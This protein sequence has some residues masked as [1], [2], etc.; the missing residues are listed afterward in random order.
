MLLN[1]VHEVPLF[2][3]T[4]GDAAKKIVEFVPNIHDLIGATLEVSEEEES[5]LDQRLK[6][7]YW[8]AIF[9]SCVLDIYVESG[10]E[11]ISLSYGIDLTSGKNFVLT[12]SADE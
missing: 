12:F 1:G 5:V 6:G 9:G 4:V 3:G 8:P 2:G 10:Q 7:M 11:R